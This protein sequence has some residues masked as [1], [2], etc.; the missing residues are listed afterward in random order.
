MVRSIL[1]SITAKIYVTKSVK[2]I[3]FLVDGRFEFI[4]DL[5]KVP[6]KR[7]EIDG[8]G[9][10]SGFFG[11]CST[12]FSWSTKRKTEGLAVSIFEPGGFSEIY[13]L[14]RAKR[15]RFGRWWPRFQRNLAITGSG[16]FSQLG[17][18]FGNG[19]VAYSVNITGQSGYRLKKT[20]L[21]NWNIPYPFIFDDNNTYH[22]C[23]GD[24][25]CHVIIN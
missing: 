17:D 1:T 7:Y 19:S 22:D 3:P 14:T 9:S 10:R 23:F 21:W 18:P 2:A 5:T 24:G 6:I 16:H 13:L 25:G 20:I 15:K 8:V 11:F 4:D 12:F